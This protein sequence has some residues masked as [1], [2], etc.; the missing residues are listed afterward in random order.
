MLDAVIAS[1]WSGPYL[2]FSSAVYYILSHHRISKRR[3]NTF[4]LDTRG[5]ILQKNPDK[6]G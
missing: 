5:N 4:C 2:H 1:N 6:N 3:G